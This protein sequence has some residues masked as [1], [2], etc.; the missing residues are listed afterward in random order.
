MPSALRG[1]RGPA[2]GRRSHV[3]R[4]EVLYLGIAF[5]SGS[6]AVGVANLTN[7]QNRSTVLTGV[8]ML[9]TLGAVLGLPLRA[10]PRAAI[11]GCRSLARQGFRRL[12][13]SRSSSRRAPARAVAAAGREEPFSQHRRH[14]C[15]GAVARRVGR[16]A[17]KR[18]QSCASNAL[19]MS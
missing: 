4:A 1:F 11:A 6:V 14:G 2:G 17:A 5:T 15:G 13:A 7:V 9:K 12:E 16:R 18:A 3:A 19:L 10:L 8:R